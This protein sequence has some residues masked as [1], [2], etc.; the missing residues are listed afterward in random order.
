MSVIGALALFF[1]GMAIDG[2]LKDYDAFKKSERERYNE[3]RAQE[4]D[5]G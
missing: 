5:R 4:K 3:W 2:W 1:A